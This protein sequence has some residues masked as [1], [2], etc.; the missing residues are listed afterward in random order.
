VCVAWFWCVRVCRCPVVREPRPPRVGVFV[1]FCFRLFSSPTS[2]A[3]C[4]RR[5]GVD[6]LCRRSSRPRP[7]R[8]RCRACSLGEASRR[9]VYVLKFSF[10]VSMFLLLFLV[11]L[12]FFFFRHFAQWEVDEEK[13]VESWIAHMDTDRD[14]RELG[15][16]KK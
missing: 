10:H 9:R 8:R 1:D 7:V 3:L 15:A 6:W 11:L 14:V 12:F 4:C 5:H 2:S 13:V 16:V